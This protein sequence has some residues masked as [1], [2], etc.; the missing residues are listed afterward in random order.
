M[1][2]F[3]W[4][5][6]IEAAARLPI[7]RPHE[8][9]DQPENVKRSKHG[10]LFS[11]KTCVLVAKINEEHANFHLRPEINL[12]D[13][14]GPS[15]H[16]INYGRFGF[17]VVLHKLFE[18]VVSHLLSAFWLLSS[19]TDFHQICRDICCLYKL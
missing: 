4:N 2:S 11:S 9:A 18:L 1:P 12:F 6:A 10:Q 15:N 13:L 5:L 19:G 7:N 17:Q 14:P 3:N 16:P 8:L